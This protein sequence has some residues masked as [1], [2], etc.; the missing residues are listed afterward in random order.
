MTIAET[1]LRQRRA[2]H[3]LFPD[4]RE[5]AWLM[6]LDLWAAEGQRPLTVSDLCFGCFTPYA[7]ALR[8]LDRLAELALAERD[9]DPTDS[10]RI[11][12]S[13]TGHAR[14]LL[15]RFAAM[16]EPERLAA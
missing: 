16:T 12:V 3:S 11:F 1:I 5:P 10:R 9:S 4:L 6:L 15:L 14:Q 2:R 8:H 13:L 7:T